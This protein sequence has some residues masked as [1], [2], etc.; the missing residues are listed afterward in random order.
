MDGLMVDPVLEC[1]AYWVIMKNLKTI[2]LSF[3][4]FMMGTV[5]SGCVI[6]P[7]RFDAQEEIRG[8]PDWVNDGS[9]M[10]ED[11]QER[12][13]YGVAFSSSQGDIALQKSIADDKSMVSVGK[14][15]AAYLEAV[16]N[17]YLLASKFA[18]QDV[19]EEFVLLSIENS[20]K[21]QIKESV[22]R[23]IDEALARQFKQGVSQ[24]FKNE[25]SQQIFDTSSRPI[26]YAITD[27]ISFARNIEEDI[28]RQI[29]EGVSRQIR[30]SV[31]KHYP[32]V[33]IVNSWRD[34]ITNNIWSQAELNLTYVKSTMATVK[35]LN[36]ELKQ[37]LANNAETIFD[38]MIIDKNTINPFAF[39]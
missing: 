15:L 26:K 9:R 28:G 13:F 10:V 16:S 34:P 25:I 18:E 8:A 23:Q 2:K 3:F 29:K 14:E 21:R 4:I 19:N 7:V 11:K 38:Q 24:E 31:P 33:R 5:V 32:G 39:K 17:S 27:Q 12:W 20:A 36:V 6:E 37:F 35:D 1:L 22:T 30:K